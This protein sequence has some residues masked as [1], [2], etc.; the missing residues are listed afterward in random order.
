MCPS[1]PYQM[2]GNLCRSAY[3]RRGEWIA[4]HR[5]QS[6]NTHSEK[7]THIKNSLKSADV[8]PLGIVVHLDDED[9]LPNGSIDM[10]RQ[11]FIKTLKPSVNV[12]IIISSIVKYVSLC[13]CVCVCVGDL[14]QV[15]FG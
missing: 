13:V 4:S 6:P 11:I 14:S 7:I 12:I 1:G 3:R 8:P 15:L 10:R 9:R 2:M 5:R